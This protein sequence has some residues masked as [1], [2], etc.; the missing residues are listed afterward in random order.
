[1]GVLEE[2]AKAAGGVI[3]AMRGSPLAIANIVLNICF[4]IFLFYYVSIIADRARATVGM[5]FAA[6]DKA[7][8]QWAAMVKDTNDL[9]EKTLHCILPSDA[10]MLLQARPAAPIPAPDRPAAPAPL[11]Q[12]K[13]P[14]FKL[15]PL[16]ATPIEL[17]EQLG[18]DSVR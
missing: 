18:P 16:P 14:V 6:Q 8:E 12:Q 4:L 10:M 3:E 11:Q 5:L 15:P 1:M 7:Y 13:S 2:G 9:T 17:R